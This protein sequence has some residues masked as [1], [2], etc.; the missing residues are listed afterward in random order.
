MSRTIGGG[1]M[2]NTGRPDVEDGLL[3]TN[4]L[5]LTGQILDLPSQNSPKGALAWVAKGA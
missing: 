5:R 1:V 4:M 3:R 2:M